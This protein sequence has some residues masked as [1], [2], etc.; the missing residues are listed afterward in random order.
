MLSP[1]VK[2]REV[3][4]GKDITRYLAKKETAIGALST[5]QSDSIEDL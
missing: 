4:S 5:L 2:G 1:A 3:G